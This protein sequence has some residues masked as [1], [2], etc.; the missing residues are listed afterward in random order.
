MRLAP[1]FALLSL[2]LS[3]AGCSLPSLEGRTDSQAVAADTTG[4]S[5]LGLAVQQLRSSGHDAALTGIYA[6][7]DPREAFAARALL[8]RAADQTLDVQYYIWRGDKTGQLLLRELLTAADRGVRV[9]LLLDD[10]GTAGLD[11]ELAALDS[12]PL[13]EVRL[14]NPFVLRTGKY[15]GYLTHFP[16]TNRRMH[17]K[18]F[19]ADNQATII[20]GRNVGNEYFGATDGVLFSDLDVL[21]IGP[22]VPEVSSDFDR[23]WNSASAYPIALLV[24]P[25]A[26]TTPDALRQ[27]YQA[28]AASAAS[29]DFA[30]AVEMTPFIQQLLQAQLPLEWAPVHLVSDDPAK[31]LGTAAQEGL[32]LPQL[33]QR[34]GM[35][36]RHLDLVSPYF[37]P[38]RSGTEALAQLQRSGVQVRVLT[39]ALEATDVAVVHS[40]YAKYR[41]PLLQAGIELFEM[42]SNNP[43]PVE[44]EDQFKLGSLGSSGTSLHAKTFAIDGQKAFV[45]SFNFDPRSAM[46]NTE[47]GFV[48]DSPVLARQISDTFDTQVP[49]RAYRVSLDGQGQLQ[50]QAQNNDGGVDTYAKEPYSSW[51]LRLLLRVLGW[52]P[53]EWLL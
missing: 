25:D 23:Y 43:Q 30:R 18:S 40:G 51:W 33:L 29:E 42:R 4:Q 11:A 19:T 46:L 16:R 6:L 44:L 50:W 35:P 26:D 45:G 9:R 20:G 1:I 39:N 41:K 34:T 3:L 53:I 5:R 13:I 32:M 21:A 47:L 49:L 2:V 52:L 31:V 28:L 17:N 12:H 10:G 48:I 24:H 7:A 27:Q 8:A 15:L 38:T 36:T 22:A 14:F 37:V